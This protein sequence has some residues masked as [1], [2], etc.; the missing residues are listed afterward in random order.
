MTK[1]LI[2]IFLN[3][4]LLLFNYFFWKALISQGIGSKMLTTPFWVFVAGFYTFVFIQLFSGE[5]IKFLYILEHELTHIVISIL[6]FK[7]VVGMNISIFKGGHVKIRGEST[8]IALAPYILPL[9]S[10]WFFIMKYFIVQKFFMFIAFLFGISE[11]FFFFRLKS[12]IHLQQTDFEYAGKIP[13]LWTILN[14]NMLFHPILLILF[15][16]SGSVLNKVFFAAG[17]HFKNF[18]QFI[19]Q[20]FL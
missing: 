12:D 7:P 14:I 9:F 3:I 16:Q 4:L 11:G 18:F 19:G 5:T 6:L 1:K 20:F 17:M 8:L 13:S 15:F 2:L 10:L